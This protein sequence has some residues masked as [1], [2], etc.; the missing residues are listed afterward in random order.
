MVVSSTS[1]KQRMVMMTSV[2]IIL[3]ELVWKFRGNKSWFSL[4]ENDKHSNLSIRITGMSEKS[5]Q[6]LTAAS[7]QNKL[8]RISCAAGKARTRSSTVT[9]H[10][11][12]TAAA[13]SDKNNH[14]S[15]A[16][17]WAINGERVT[18]VS[19]GWE[20][21]DWSHALHYDGG[22]LASPYI[23]KALHSRPG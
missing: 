7:I 13:K 22:C 9:A 3:S 15:K 20:L 6:R 16:G 8:R 1:C 17:A 11:N 4:K 14:G 12:S 10:Q 21:G 23:P 19:Q 5:S 2:E 18:S